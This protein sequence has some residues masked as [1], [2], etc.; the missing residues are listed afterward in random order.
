MLNEAEHGITDL[1][2][3]NSRFHG[4]ETLLV[5]FFMHPRQNL[6]KSTTEGRAIFEETPYIQ[7]MTP[8]NKDHIIV[9]PASDMDKRRFA[10]HFRK[11][12]AREDQSSVEGTLLEEWA[13]ITRSQAEEL[14]FLNI[15]TVEQL[16]VV[17][18][19]NAQGVMGIAFLKEKAQKFIEQTKG[20]EVSKALADMQAKYDA[21]VK[22][23][24]ADEP[25][26]PKRKRRTKA[27]MEAEKQSEQLG[28]LVNPPA[29]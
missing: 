2:M 25:E 28:N 6:I 24:A 9:R 20:E 10:E 3:N 4:D 29:E 12:E 22:K 17:S 26:K 1:A 11:F 5:K 27:E 16:S 8:G 18:D 21:L 7:I 15:R 23:V 14:R 19:S 13:G